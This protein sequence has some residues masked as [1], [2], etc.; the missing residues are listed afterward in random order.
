MCHGT[1]IHGHKNVCI[2]MFISINL[3]DISKIKPLWCTNRDPT[4]LLSLCGRFMISLCLVMS[5]WR[6]RGLNKQIQ[7]VFHLYILLQT[8]GNNWS[9]Q[10]N[11]TTK[12]NYTSWLILSI[13]YDLLSRR[14]ATLVLFFSRKI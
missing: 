11:L 2:I 12:C 10:Q 3:R 5:P 7:L 9:F 8:A 13:L 1:A 14:G 6:K 4:R